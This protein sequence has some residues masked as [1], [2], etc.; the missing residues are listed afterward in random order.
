MTS[1]ASQPDTGAQAERVPTSAANGPAGLPSLHVAVILNPRS[2]RNARAIPALDQP[3]V[4]SMAPRT[5]PELE[6]ALADFANA[7]VPVLAIGGGDGT[8]RDVLT[9][10]MPIFGDEWPAILVLPRGKTNALALDLGLPG[11]WPVREALRAA[12]AGRTVTRQPL[13]VESLDVPD[14]RRRLGFILGAGVFN[15]AIEAGQVAHR[16]GAF[17]SFAVAVTAAAGVVQAIFATAGNPWRRPW[18][19]RLRIGGSGGPEIP[20][21]GKDSTAGRFFVLL[22]TLSAFPLGVRPFAG[23]AEPGKIRYFVIDAPRRRMLAALPG[24]FYGKRPASRAKLG[25]H[26]GAAGEFALELEDSFILD[27]ESFPSGRYQVTTGPAL[28]FIVP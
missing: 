6:A 3:G 13:M 20:H 18:T 7:K 19:M 2:H 24:V 10:G 22:S 26:Q 27:G 28:R 15:A 14:S 1:A 9:R 25:I 23:K 16:H 21:S 12:R 5:K 8:V 17:Q 4:V 11:K